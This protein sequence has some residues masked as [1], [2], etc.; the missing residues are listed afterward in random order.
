MKLSYSE[1]MN[2]FQRF[3][4]KDIDKLIELSVRFKA[5]RNYEKA[6]ITDFLLRIK[7]LDIEGLK[8]LKTEL[9]RSEQWIE[10]DYTDSLLKEKLRIK[11]KEEKKDN[12]EKV[13]TIFDEKSQTVEQKSFA[14]VPALNLSEEVSQAMA[15]KIKQDSKRHNDHINNLFDG[16]KKI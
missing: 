14:F 8:N 6:Q 16:E 9:Q 7:K 13:N 12:N 1:R 3:K 11:L 5:N 2:L 4:D 10:F 15:G